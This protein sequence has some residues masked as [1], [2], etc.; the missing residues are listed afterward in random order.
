MS[1]TGVASLQ[2]ALQRLG[3]A[4]VHNGQEIIAQDQDELW[5]HVKR[6]ALASVIGRRVES[7]RFS[8]LFVAC[9]TSTCPCFS[10]I[11]SLK[12]HYVST[13]N[14]KTSLP[15]RSA[16]LGRHLPRLRGRA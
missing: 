1:R 6:G 16:R 3:Y 5:R 11:G 10:L 8:H 13:R 4:P 7:R 12:V 9:Y 15:C 2:A 14:C